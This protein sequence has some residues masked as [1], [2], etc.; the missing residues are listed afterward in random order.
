MHIVFLSGEYPLWTSGGVGTFIQTFGRSLVQNGHM[1]SVVGPGKEKQELKLEDDGIQIYRL[2]KSSGPLPNF[3][4]NAFQI[5]KKLRQLHKEHPIA[6]IEAAEGGLAL[7][8]KGHAAKKIIRL[9]GGHHFFSEAEKR[10]INW[11]KGWLEKK[12]FTKADGFIAISQYVKDHTANYLSYSNRPI[13]IISLPLDTS[14]QIP[15]V[16]VQKDHILFAGTVCE[17]KGV[18]QLIQAFKIVR[19]KYP[20]K[21]LNLFGREWFYPD[22]ISYHQMLTEKY[23]A[24]YFENVYFHGS[25]SRDTLDKKYVE[26]AFCVFP[27]HMETQGLVSIEAMLLGKTVIF[28]KYGPGP[29]T[30]EHQKT[31]LLCDVYDPMDIAEKMI[32]CIEHPQEAALLGETAAKLVKTRYD[33]NT[34]LKRNVQFYQSLIEN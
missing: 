6:I 19:E 23:D 16:E 21:I 30:V 5:N 10:K 4:F 12:S 7:L 20:N 24:S 2:P 32:W 15:Q 26:A 33:A 11:R 34:I 1:V 27:S 22:G 31:G 28:S 18:R 29:E 25:I 14:K 8:S 9:H 17:K 3:V 13:D